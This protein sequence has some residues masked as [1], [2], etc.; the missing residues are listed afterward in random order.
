[1]VVV[2]VTP[3][4]FCA[5]RLL[6]KEIKTLKLVGGCQKV[7]VLLYVMKHIRIHI[8]LIVVWP[9]PQLWHGRSPNHYP[10]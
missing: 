1:M 5:L 9:E 8:S 3:V 4:V 10:H 2:V 7:Y 6:K